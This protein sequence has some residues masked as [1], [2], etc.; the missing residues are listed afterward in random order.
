MRIR[1]TTDLRAGTE[2][3]LTLTELMAAMASVMVIVLVGWATVEMGH[4]EVLTASARAESNQTI[5]AVIQAIEEN[6][7]Q[8]SAVAIPD[9]DYSANS[10]IQITVPT[11]TGSV[12]RAYRLE[13]N[14]LVIDYKDE[15]A[16]PFAAFSGVTALNFTALDEPTNSLIQV[17]CTVAFGGEAVNMRTVARKRN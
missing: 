9:P 5:F 6:V 14:A 12:R 2:P 15:S 10:S 3:G 1:R 7:M 8:A 4:R 11:E 13:D 17:T 16:G